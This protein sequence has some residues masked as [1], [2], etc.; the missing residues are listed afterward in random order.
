M[1]LAALPDMPPPLAGQARAAGMLSRLLQ[2]KLALFGIVIIAIVVVLAAAAPIVAPYDPAEQH[3]DGLTLEGAP[4]PPSATFWLG[5]DLLG[6]RSFLA[7][8]LRRAHVARRRHRRERR[9]R[10]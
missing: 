9:G 1:S 3:F 5:T 4:L 6:T 7:A 8:P 10:R 2:R